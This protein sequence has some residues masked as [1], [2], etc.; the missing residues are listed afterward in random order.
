MDPLDDI[1]SLADAAEDLGLSAITLRHQAK[2]G[3]LRA[4]LV[5]KTWITTRDEVAR[6]RRDNLGKAGRPPHAPDPS[7]AT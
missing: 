7:D 3:R 5:G 6:Y 4:R 1:I 2:A